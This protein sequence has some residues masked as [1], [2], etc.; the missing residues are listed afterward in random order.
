[1]AES[2][3]G[4]D[5]LFERTAD[6]AGDMMRSKKGDFVITLDP[7]TVRGATLRLVVECKDRKMSGRAM[8]DELAEAR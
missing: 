5:H 6:A 3:R 7:E 8:R 2:L 1:M 4:S